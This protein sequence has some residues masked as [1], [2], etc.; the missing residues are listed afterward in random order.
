MPVD[1]VATS[2]GLDFAIH[3]G[4]VV[5]FL[6]GLVTALV[7]GVG[8]VVVDG[9]AAMKPS[10]VRI[11]LFGGRREAGARLV[12]RIG[13][14]V[15]V[16]ST[17]AVGL[18]LV[19]RLVVSRLG[20]NDGLGGASGIVP[21]ILFTVEI[22]LSAGLVFGITAWLEAPIDVSAAVSPADLLRS[23]RRNAIFQFFTWAIV[24]G[25]VT[26]VANNFTA[27]A[28]SFAAGNVSF[29]SSFINSV[30]VGLVFG[31]EG[32]F[33]AGIGYALCLTAWGQ[34]LVLAR[35]WLPLTGRLP[36]RLVAFLDDACRRGALRR[37][38]AV[39]QFRHA[40]LQDHLIGV[41]KLGHDHPESAAA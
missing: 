34:W 9:S 4:L 8:Y 1:L 25:T 32:A 16:G 28:G 20:L 24:L 10:P 33:G 6:H 41:P 31:I 13:S 12:A 29:T 21:G 38:G 30:G 14:G 39:Y 22:G 19:D 27:V 23:N 11:R 37:A 35:I 15:L 17:V 18:A 3:R 26:G 40:R 2:Y 5:G 7:F 36:W